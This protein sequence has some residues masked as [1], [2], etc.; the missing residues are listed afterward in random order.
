M[1]NIQS[2]ENYNLKNQPTVVGNVPNNV[3]NM[4]F[5]ASD[6]K[7]VRQPS[8]LDQQANMRRA[9]EEQKKTEKK[10]KIKQNL[11][12][13][14]GIGA[15]LVL[16]LALG[17]PMLSSFFGKEGK[18][19]K[20][21]TKKVAQ[22][23][24]DVI[25][26]EAEEELA[27]QAHERSLYRVA[28]LV[29]LD[30][31]ASSMEARTP[32]DIGAVKTALGKKIIGQDKAK[33]PIYNFLEAINYDIA[34]D[35]PANAPRI[36]AIDGPPGTCKSTLMKEAS[37]S[38]GMYLK[39]ISL[40]NIDK[41]GSL[42]GFERTYVGA[43]AGAFA[44]GQLE[45]GTKKV[46]YMLDELEKAPIEVQNALLSLLD[47]QAKFKDL[48][49]NCEIDL[50][51]TIFG[52]TTNELERLRGTALYDRIKPFVIK[53]SAYDDGTKAKIAKLK[54]QEALKLNKM[55]SKVDIKEEVY[56]IIAN[57][58]TDQ[59]GRETTQI[60]EKKLID[61][62]KKLLNHKKGN[63]KIVVDKTFIEKFLAEN[64]QV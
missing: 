21:L 14:L 31:L 15:S 39:K 4:T 47:D 63:E 61:E 44:T 28:D 17:G 24:N 50:S 16:I 7:F 62:L 6:D 12:W 29:Q 33:E 48:Y 37:D 60:A 32:A 25:K 22:I 43:K 5:K 26:R 53:V 18:Q 49:Y 59:G 11:T 55:S 52:I 2:V 38:L 56:D 46:F 34:N 64:K 51:Q 58:T 27:R 41:P 10:Q 42:V 19:L 23:K 45:G 1:L 36:I 54:I 30:E 20:E 13:G 8:V 9:L 3:K 35:I 40:N 57:S